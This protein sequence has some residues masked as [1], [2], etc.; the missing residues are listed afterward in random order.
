MKKF[1]L[2]LL[3]FSF[4]LSTSA[5]EKLIILNEGNWQSDNGRVTYFEND[6]VVSN[7]WFRDVN[8]YKLG[9]TPEDIIHVAP[10]LIAITVNWS[11]IVQFIDAAGHAVAQT[12]DVPN[13]R[14][15]ATDGRYVYVTSYAHECLTV[16]GLKQFT[17]GFVAKIDTRSFKVVDAAEVGYEA[18]GIALYDGH[19]FVANT[20]GYAATENDHDYERTVTVLNAASLATVRTIDTG[21]INLCGT[22]S[23]TGNT[24]ASTR[25][26][27]TMK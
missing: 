22:L 17:K 5:Q 4:V 25:P 26:V 2:S 21:H 15:M 16:S 6:R 14:K 10:D 7:S 1:F 12:E 23:Q 9:D 3:G 11:N 20:G 18:E 19:L 27:T 8:G 13:C 24:S